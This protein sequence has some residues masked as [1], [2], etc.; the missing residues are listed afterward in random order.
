MPAGAAGGEGA[1]LKG[2]PLRQESVAC[3]GGWAA[4]SGGRDTDL[5]HADGEA[6]EVH[7]V[8]C[9]DCEDSSELFEG[10]ID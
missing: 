6:T 7:N 1:S 3:R 8:A 4:S 5:G 2:S 9:G 10:T